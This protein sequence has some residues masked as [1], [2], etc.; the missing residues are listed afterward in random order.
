[1]RYPLAPTPSSHRS[2]IR[3]W[4]WALLVLV[5]ACGGGDGGTTP[6][7]PPPATFTVTVTV[8][9]SGEDLDPD[10]YTVAV[11]STAQQVGT[12]AT[13][14]F[15]GVAA[16]THEVALSGLA[17]NCQVEGGAT[18]PVT[19]SG[20]T[21]LTLIV[22]CRSVVASGL[23]APIACPALALAP[24]AGLPSAE[25]KLGTLP[26]A[27]GD[28]VYLRASWGGGT[29]YVLVH[30]ERGADGTAAT[31][32]PLHPGR[33]LEG[34]E[35]TLRV[36]GGLQACPAVTLTVAALPPAPGELAAVVGVLQ[37][38]IEAQAARAGVTV[39]TLK[40]LPAAT[41]PRRL[42][43]LAIAQSVVDRPDNPNSLAAVVAGTAPLAA[44]IDP[45]LLDR[46]L[47]LT[48]MRQ[49]FS[50]VLGSI[51]ARPVARATRSQVDALECVVTEID[52]ATLLDQCMA[53]GVE[54]A[55]HS[56]G[57]SN[58]VLTHIGWA[59][60]AAAAAPYPAV[61]LAAALASA[62][63]WAHQALQEGTAS[64]LP[65]EFVDI[66]VEAAPEEFHE[67]QEGPGDWAAEVRATSTGWSLDKMALDVLNKLMGFTSAHE[68]FATRYLDPQVLDF[69]KG[70]IEAAFI[71][72]LL[73]TAEGSG[74]VS[75]APEIF[76]PVDVSD[77]KWTVRNL[78]PDGP[79]EF[80]SHTAYEPRE[81]G[82]TLLGVGTR[83]GAFGGRR[84]L[85]N[86][87]LPLK[88]NRIEIDLVHGGQAQQS[89]TVSTPSQ[90]LVIE[91]HVR[92]A[93][94]PEHVVLEDDPGRKGTASLTPGAPGT[95]VYV[96]PADLTQL[97]DV[98]AVRYTGTTGARAGDKEPRVALLEIRAAQILVTPD[99]ACVAPGGTQQYEAIV[100]GLAS[101]PITWSSSLGSIS[102][103]GLFT[104]PSGVPPGTEVTITASLK[105]D[106]KVTA[107]VTAI[108]GC[109]CGFEVTVGGTTYT[110]QP[111][112]RASY[113][114]DLSRQDGVITVQLQSAATGRQVLFAMGGAPVVPGLYPV[115][116]VGGNLAYPTEQGY[117]RFS[118]D[119][120]TFTLT[121]YTPHTRLVGGFSG[122]VRD[123]VD[124]AEGA[125][126]AITA[127]FQ[128]FP[129]PDQSS[130]LGRACVIPE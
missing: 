87:D 117:S 5:P 122:T 90:P 130:F 39:A 31:R 104:A 91:V 124:G 89:M 76:G 101:P 19:V 120:V 41:L 125:A 16:G 28:P 15:T 85:L 66:R 123:A 121:Q 42:L 112:D 116:D 18:R 26:A 83:D 103:S 86:P 114:P 77:P 62:G 128:I 110:G 79:L 3:Q 99:G 10:G 24:A 109:V 17:P 107:S 84:I 40:Q 1:M 126:L 78:F 129:T 64:L 53:I 105:S 58:D 45:V 50:Q 92:N 47:G 30:V 13:A 12:A 36:A 38:L 6:G 97:P 27:L 37:S 8:T 73:D 100:V 118:E 95:L 65:T 74:I 34:G 44:G 33:P 113:M 23:Y 43:P 52:T 22:T 81:P 127:T 115:S 9:T 94:Y 75:I 106:S 57:A 59:L 2:L 55:F 72:T 69:L 20:S 21:D 88:V 7:N 71:N 102:S 14:T 70:L 25:L 96:A 32:V 29:E 119:D 93:K 80:V 98:L 82:E 35:L 4:P 60:D 48:G 61:K 54:A 111:G 108:V 63:V 49:H 46:M 67:D 11:G 68:A 56:T 51:R